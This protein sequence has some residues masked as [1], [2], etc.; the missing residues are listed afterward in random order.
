M[1]RRSLKIL[2]LWIVPLLIARALIPAGYM[3]MADGD[4]L[5]VVFCPAVVQSHDKAMP[6]D[7][8]AAHHHADPDGQTAS[9]DEHG[10]GRGGHDHAPCPFSLVASAALLD[11]SHVGAAL[12]A[13][14]QEDVNFL[15]QPANSTGPIR[16]DRIR[17]PPQFS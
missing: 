5:E 11:V 16:T 9:G 15:S 12:S 1:N 4:G 17:G 2:S 14:D 7:Q 10:P 3:V 8:H 13:T 6:A